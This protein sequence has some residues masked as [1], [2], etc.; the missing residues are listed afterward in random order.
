MLATVSSPKAKGQAEAE[1]MRL[2]L[3]HPGKPSFLKDSATRIVP[4]WFLDAAVETENEPVGILSKR[5]AEF[6][7]NATSTAEDDKFLTAAGKATPMW[8]CIPV[9]TNEEQIMKG[10]SLVAK[11]TPQEKKRK[12]G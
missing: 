11:L 4:L 5:F 7:I 12:L 6:K 10:S 9:Y 2:W 8:L 1:D 3:C